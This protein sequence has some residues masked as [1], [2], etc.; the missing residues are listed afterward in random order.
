L[1]G[2]AFGYARQPLG[3]SERPPAGEVTTDFHKD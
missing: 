3:P 2:C 1:M